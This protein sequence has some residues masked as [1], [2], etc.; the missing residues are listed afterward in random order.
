M[1]KGMMFADLPIKLKLV[2]YAHGGYADQPIQEV[3]TT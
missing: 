2:Y 1:T 3:N